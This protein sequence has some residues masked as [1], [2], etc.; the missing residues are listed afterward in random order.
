MRRKDREVTDFNTIV[1]IIDECNVLRIGLADDDYPYIVPLN[2]G[3]RVEG[4]Q[5]YFYIHGAMAGRKYELMNKLKKCSC[6]MDVPL[7]IECMPERKSVTMKY[8]SVM[9]KANIKFLYGE[10]RVLAMDKYIMGRYENTKNFEYNKNMLNITC[11][12]E[13]RVTEFTGKMNI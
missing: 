11:V 7:K 10:E 5:I 12:A 6:E 9:G 13:L 8:K 2:F 4:E 3:Y 1:S